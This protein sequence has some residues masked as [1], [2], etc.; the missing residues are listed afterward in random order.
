MIFLNSL[1]LDS[2]NFNNNNL[3]VS[4]VECDVC[5]VGAGIFGMTC[6]YY[7]TKLGLDVVVLEK[8]T[9]CSKT[10]GHTTGKITSQHGLFYKHL[11]DDYG[12]N[13]ARLYLQ[14]NEDAIENIKNIVN[15]EKI[16]CDFSLQNSYV[17][18]TTKQELNDV[19][20]EVEAVRSLNFPCEFASTV[21]LPFE[22]CGSVCFKNQAQFNPA[23]YVLGLYNSIKNSAHVFT[24]ITVTDIRKDF[25]DR[26]VCFAASSPVQ[27]SS[28]NNDFPSY[29][30][31]SK[32]VIMASHYPF[33]NF[34]GFY[35]TKMY[36]STSYVIAIDPKK[37]L[38]NG[39]FLSA[40]TPTFSFRTAKF[41]NKNLLLIAGS[42]HK[43]GSFCTEA[44]SYKILEDVAKKYYPDCDI[45]YRWNTRDCI[46]LDKIPYIGQ[47]SDSLPNFFVATS[48]KK[49]GM[50][51]SNVAANI[52]V[53]MI[54]GKENPYFSVYSSDRLQPIKNMDEFKNVIVQSTKSLVIDKIKKSNISFDSIPL[55]SGAIVEINNQKIGIFR[56]SNDDIFAVKPFCTHLGCLLSWNDV[57]KTWDCP[58]H[59]FSL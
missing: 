5:I 49:W 14:S 40:G 41:G 20:A 42:D 25:D 54:T 58:C 37:S 26:Y 30:I 51:L 22:T 11:I 7:L 36:Q 15:S 39:M 50:S 9:I 19:K 18:S 34:P 48:F 46:S 31:K 23:K 32:Y 45:L 44:S 1:W 21:G 6:A 55:N 2:V 8:D 24:N 33:I 3:N 59:R 38:F 4:D 57:D 10:T 29:K 53:D 13:F 28:N 47:Y 17:Y 56:D 12:Y 35:F 27:Y 43:T 16:S 52:I